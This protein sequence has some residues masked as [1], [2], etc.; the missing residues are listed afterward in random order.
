MKMHYALKFNPKVI[1]DLKDEDELDNVVSHGDDIVELPHVEAI[2]E[3]KENCVSRYAFPKLPFNVSL[4]EAIGVHVIR[5]VGLSGGCLLFE[6][7]R[8]LFF[9]LGNIGEVLCSRTRNKCIS[10]G[11]SVAAQPQIRQFAI[12]MDLKQ[13]AAIIFD[14]DLDPSE[15]LVSMHDTSLSRGNFA[16]FQGDNWIGN[17]V[18][19]V[20]CRMLQFNDVSR[21]KLFLSPYIAEVVMRSN[22]KHLMHDAVI[23]RFEPYLYPLD[24]SY[25]NVNE[26]GQGLLLSVRLIG[27]RSGLDQYSTGKDEPVDRCLK[28]STGSFYLLDERESSQLGLDRFVIGCR[29][30][31]GYL[32]REG[33][34]TG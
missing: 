20:Y 29:L 3:N 31:R 26:R 32:N 19:D 28:T 1:Q 4:S 14:G 30:V 6:L 18:V 34:G 11:H 27:T 16:F 17:G 9:P 22:A 25:Q 10:K 12:K 24:V 2:E 15:E 23:A 5:Q 21:T 8:E 7:R 33:Q 13:A